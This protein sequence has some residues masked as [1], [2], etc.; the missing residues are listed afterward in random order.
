MSLGGVGRKQMPWFVQVFRL[1]SFLE[2][3]QGSLPL[4][5]QGFLSLTG[6]SVRRLFFE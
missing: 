1:K 4:L 5:M 6:E 2:L 3:Q